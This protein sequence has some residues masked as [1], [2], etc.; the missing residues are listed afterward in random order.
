MQQFYW[1]ARKII[2]EKK[3]ESKYFKTREERDRFVANHPEWKKRGK[4][5]TENLDKH[6]NGN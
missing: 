4:I 6:L 2:D 5:C 3:P 1:T